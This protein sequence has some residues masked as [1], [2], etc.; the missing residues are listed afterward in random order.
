MRKIIA[1]IILTIIIISL[2]NAVD[3]TTA[4]LNKIYILYNHQDFTTAE[5]N[6][7]SLINNNPKQY[8]IYALELGDF[9]LDK[10]T[11]YKKAESI[12]QSL[13]GKF[14]K[15]KNNGDIYYR[16]GVVYEKQ[17]MY[18]QAAQMDEMVAT[19][20]RKSQYAQDG[21]DA[22]E[23]CFK[24]NY[25]DLAAI[26]NGFPITRIEFDDRMLQNPGA[27]E[28][29]EDRQKLLND[30]INERIMYKEALNRGFDQTIEFKTRIADT[31]KNIMFQ[32]WY[33]KEAVN[34]VKIT[35][36]EKKSYYNKNKQEFITP[37]QASAR[38][39]LV[40]TKPEADS[41]YRLITI[42]NLPFDSVAQ[43]T[44]LAPTKSAG[45]DLGYFRRGTHPKEVEDVIFKLK[46]KQISTPFYSETKGG[47]VIVQLEDYKPKKV[48][49]YKEIGRA[50]V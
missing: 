39:I 50:H 20:Y 15:H 42:Y 6:L 4:E 9:Y 13:T 21:L 23:R 34:S 43:E 10:L 3:L 24:K 30:M 17:E 12:Y 18:L 38:E 40:K 45:G 31:R 47:Y 11:N 44:S 48:R 36:N 32:Q 26:V 1:S 37:E 25:Q 19:K 46:L 5:Q 27:Y 49:S 35:E 16:L 28:K 14:P 33:Q 22:I 8:F 41:L 7:L 2:S 29:F